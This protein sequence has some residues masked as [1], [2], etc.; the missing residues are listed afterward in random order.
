MDETRRRV[1]LLH[2]A[3]TAVFCLMLAG[4]F[5]DLLSAVA[6]PSPITALLERIAARLPLLFY[7]W[8]LWAIG[9]AFR[10]VGTTD[11]LDAAIA[12]VLSRVGGALALG[13]VFTLV[14][15]PVLLR[16]VSGGRG[17]FVAY[18]PA[19]M[20]LLVIGLLMVL[21]AGT[22]ARMKAMRDELDGFV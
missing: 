7:L 3:V 17:G 8:A 19:A 13:A 15:S 21:L 2:A 20:T 18:D 1:R 4:A 11:D 22:V 16:I 9:G 10:L 5:I 14:G 6:A 12:R